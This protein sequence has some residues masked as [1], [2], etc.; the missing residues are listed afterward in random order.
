MATLPCLPLLI[1]Q[2]PGVHSCFVL[3]S[4]PLTP[5]Q[6]Q[7]KELELVW[8]SVAQWEMPIGLFAP[9]LLVLSWPGRVTVPTL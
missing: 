2:G 1:P 6:V 7:D 4:W 8:G 5:T 3:E 9:S